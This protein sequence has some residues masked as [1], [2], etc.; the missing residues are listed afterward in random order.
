MLVP[1]IKNSQLKKSGLG[2]FLQKNTKGNNCTLHFVF[3]VLCNTEWLLSG[4]HLITY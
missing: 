1:L 2:V 3:T 4:F